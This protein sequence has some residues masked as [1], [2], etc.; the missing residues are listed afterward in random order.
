MAKK[1]QGG[2]YPAQIIGTEQPLSRTPEPSP[3]FRPQIPAS[4]N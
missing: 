2:K 3:S 1:A 4:F